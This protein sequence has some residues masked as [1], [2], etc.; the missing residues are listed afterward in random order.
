MTGRPKYRDIR[1]VY[2]LVG[3]CCELG[4]DSTQWRQHMLEQLRVLSGARLALYMHIENPLAAQEQI[5]EPLDNGFL[6]DHQRALWFHYQQTEAYKED[7]F[8]QGYLRRV[9]RRVFTRSLTDV[10]DTKD[11]NR[12]RVFN[13]YIRPCELND[14]I[15]SAV[16]LSNDDTRA[17]QVLV[18]HRDKR[19]HWYD[20]STTRLIHLFH[21]EMMHYWGTRLVVPGS[22][23]D[24]SHIS[25][26][27]RDILGCL[28][29]GDSEKQI[30]LKLNISRHTVNNHIQRLYRHFGVRSRAELFHRCQHLVS[31]LTTSLQ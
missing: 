18:L 4:A 24:L 27:L 25:P 20:R 16:Q 23:Q 8:H 1:A 31:A 14:R 26:R 28:L 3:E 2:R 15:S 9:G 30:A 12:S 7:Q 10:V 19:D 6:E 5:I 11:W 13:D 21:H 17:L 29:V 22:N